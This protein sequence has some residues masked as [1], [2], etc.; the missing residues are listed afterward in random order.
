MRIIFFFI[1]CFSF[2]FTNSFQE[3]FFGRSVNENDFGIEG[4]LWKLKHDN[5]P[6]LTPLILIPGLTGS[7][8]QD[9]L[10]NAD[11]P[12][13]CPKNKDWERIW[14]EPGRMVQVSCFLDQLRQTFDDETQS[15]SN[16]EGVEMDTIDFGGVHG[17]DYLAYNSDGYP[18]N[19]TDYLAPLIANLESAGYV[20]GQN[21]AAAPYDWRQTK[22]PNNWN[23][24]IKQLIETMYTDNSNTPVFVLC[25]S[26]G[27]LEFASF[28]ETVDQSWKDQYV[29]GFI[30]AAAPWSGASLAIR[31]LISGVEVSV[32]PVTI[33]PFEIASLIQTFGSVVWM[34]PTD[35]LLGDEPVVVTDTT[36]YASSNFEQL[37]E[38]INATTT[39][40]IYNSLGNSLTELPNPNVPIYCLYGTNK[41][42]ELWYEYGNGLNEQP[43]VIH[44]EQEGDG[45]VP[46]QSLKKCLSM[47]P[48]STRTFNLISHGDL[49]KDPFFFNEVMNILNGEV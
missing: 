8:L 3:N 13:L 6:V 19:S 36:S 4:K 30:S 11:L 48:V 46:I 16:T 9:K 33:N 39:E 15:F 49:V 26:M 1:L 37:F 28:M 5:I 47:N 35:N 22:N 25:H 14:I 44:Y 42:T 34:V 32:G 23:A 27:N 29:G 10:D 7:G 38:D 40:S 20:V 41:Q 2:I 45:V 18:I 21:L 17:V 12:F 24:Q 31:A 43:T